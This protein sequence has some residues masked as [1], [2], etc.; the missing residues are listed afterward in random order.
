MPIQPVLNIVHVEFSQVESPQTFH[1]VF[2]NPSSCGHDA[3]D[4]AVLGK[5]ADDLSHS[6]RDHVGGVSEEDGAANLGSV[7]R[8]S[9]LLVVAFVERLVREAP[10][11]HGI[12]DLDGLV[13]VGGLEPH[14]GVVLKD[15]G[16]VYSLIEVVALDDL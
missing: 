9:G 1:Y 13:K 3:I 15:F 5:V 2:F 12:D 4:H 14:S 8:L 7:G 10:V 11:Y 16:V 6:T